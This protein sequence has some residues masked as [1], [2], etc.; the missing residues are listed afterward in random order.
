MIGREVV[1]DLNSLRS[2]GL[3]V[4]QYFDTATE[5]GTTPSFTNK[6]T[7]GV[8]PESLQDGKLLSDVSSAD[9]E[10]GVSGWIIKANGD[11][12]FNDGDFRGNVEV[13]SIDIGGA[14]TTS[15]HI[16]ADGNFWLGAATFAAAPARISNQGY[17]VFENIAVGGDTIQYVITN[18]GIFSFGD[19]SDGDATCDGST[20]VTGMSLGGSTYTMTRDVYFDNF[21]VNS[22]VTVNTGGYRIFV[23]D[24]CTIA[25]TVHRNGTNGGNG[26]NGS[27][28]SAGGGGSG[29]TMSDG[30]LKGSGVAPGGGSGGSEGGGGGNGTNG[31]SVSNCLTNSN[32]ATGGAAGYFGGGLPLSGSGSSGGTATASNVKLIANWHLATLLDISSTGATVKFTPSAGSGSGGGGGGGGGGSGNSGGGGGGAGGG[33]G[34]VAIY[35]RN[36]IIQATGVISANGGNGGNGGNGSNS[37]AGRGGGGGGGNGGVIVLTYNSIT[38]SGSLTVSAGTKGLKGTSGASSGAADGGNGSVGVIYQFE[39]SL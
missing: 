25:G 33:G 10:A 35:A 12:E 9:Y 32:G 29:S 2:N 36:L 22:G 11:V 26:G 30:Y 24:T 1:Y 18:S 19:G 4:D 34:I 28:A 14:D 15:A 8:S 39:L 16:D 27:G 17:A 7:D 20:A 37:F 31:T 3:S 38:N 6:F 23:K 21:T 13:G 5:D